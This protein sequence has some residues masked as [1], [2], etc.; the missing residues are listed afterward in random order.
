M[1]K[2]VAVL[3]RT[4]LRPPLNTGVVVPRSRVR[5]MVPRPRLPPR[6]APAVDWRAT[7]GYGRSCI[8]SCCS[9]PRGPLRRGAG[10]GGGVFRAQSGAAP[11]QPQGAVDLHT[12]A[13]G[14]GR[15]G[16]AGTARRN[17][18]SL[19]RGVRQAVAARAHLLLWRDVD[20]RLRGRLVRGHAAA[21]KDGIRDEDAGAIYMWTA[22]WSIVGARV[23]YVITQFQEFSNPVD[24]VML[25]KGGLV[26]YGGMLGG[27]RQAGMAAT[28]ARSSCCAGLTCPRP[29][30]CWARRSPAWGACCSAATT[31]RCRTY[32]GPFASP[33]TRRPGRTTCTACTRWLPIRHGHFPFIRRRSTRR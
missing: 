6:Q 33:R 11:A 29:R 5:T 3:Q 2:R 8:R 7:S 14:G 4:G 9:S 17:L 18:D 12:D 26:A 25:N 22:V 27:F 16:A 30:W 19:G 15:V 20:H 28:G 24:I 32:P 31:A 13:A 23:L 1:P 10:L 21:R